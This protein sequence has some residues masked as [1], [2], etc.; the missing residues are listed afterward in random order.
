VNPHDLD[1]EKVLDLLLEVGREAALTGTATHP[2]DL[3]HVITNAVEV[4]A[5][6]IALAARKGYV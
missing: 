5:E 3:A 1:T 6:T 4:A 2:V